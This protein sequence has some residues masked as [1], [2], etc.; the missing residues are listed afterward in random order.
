MDFKNNQQRFW[1]RFICSLYYA[2][3]GFKH[4]IYHE[5]NMKIHL[6]IATVV[7][8]LAFI[9]KIPF[10]EKLILL[11]VIGIVI[12]LEMVNTAIERV[13]DLVTQEYHP[14]AK[15]A[16][17]IS[18]GAVFIFSIVTVIVG[19]LIFYQPILKIVSLYLKW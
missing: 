15:V 8:S 16:K 2:W 11:I 4:V 13:V 17:D 10:Y 12:C 7:I 1:K 3:S 19:N 6:M 14:L 5:Q 18:A 9:L